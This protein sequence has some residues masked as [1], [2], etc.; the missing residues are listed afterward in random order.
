M[1]AGGVTAAVLRPAVGAPGRPHVPAAE[2]RILEDRQASLRAKVEAS[3][4][5]SAGASDADS[6][7]RA[8]RCKLGLDSL[9]MQVAVRPAESVQGFERNLPRRGKL[10]SLVEQERRGSSGEFAL[11]VPKQD[12]RVLV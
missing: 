9:R 6:E 12:T 5:L 8:G 11:N 3:D 10:V 1:I 4:K 7:W 2:R